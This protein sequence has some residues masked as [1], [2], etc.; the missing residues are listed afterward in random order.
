M[1]KRNYSE[2]NDF[3]SYYNLFTKIFL[4]HYN[5]QKRPTFVIKN[6]NI[7]IK[8]YVRSGS[9]SIRNLH[10]K[11]IY[12]LLAKII[13]N[14]NYDL[15][16]IRYIISKYLNKIRRF[17]LVLVN[18][19][20]VLPENFIIK[21]LLRN[22]NNLYEVNFIIR[23]FINCI[24]I[25]DY[26]KPNELFHIMFKDKW[27]LY[28]VYKNKNIYDTVPYEFKDVK[29]ILSKVEVLYFREQNFRNLNYKLKNNGAIFKGTQNHYIN[30]KFDINESYFYK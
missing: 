24:I 4:K 17:P 13:S 6:K 19:Y 21:N 26:I 15:S 23:E 18:E 27:D 2:S 10:K 22:H 30:K 8:V 9:K 28:Y 11:Y 3:Y 12:K 29:Y 20:I 25:R 14:E 16:D 7:N 1:Q 5:N